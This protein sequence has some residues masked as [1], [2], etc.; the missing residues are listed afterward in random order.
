VA[1]VGNIT[2]SNGVA[3]TGDI[4]AGY[5]GGDS[6]TLQHHTHGRV[7]PGGGGTAAPNAGT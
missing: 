6:V 4:T 1:I 3:V 7:V 2:A 5:G